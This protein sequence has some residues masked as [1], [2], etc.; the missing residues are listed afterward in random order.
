V[1]QIEVNWVIPTPSGD[2][3]DEPLNP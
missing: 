1:N 2:Q 3:R